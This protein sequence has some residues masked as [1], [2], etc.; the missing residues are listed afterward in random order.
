MCYGNFYSDGYGAGYERGWKEAMESAEQCFL[1]TARYKVR[2]ILEEKLGA[3]ADNHRA[4]F[5]LEYV[6]PWCGKE[7]DVE[8]REDEQYLV[9]C[10][11]RVVFVNANSP[12]QAAEKCVFILK[13]LADVHEDDGTMLG[14]T[15][16]KIEDGALTVGNPGLGI[17]IDLEDRKC[18]VRLPHITNTPKPDRKETDQ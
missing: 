9:K 4:L 16:P 17:D 8:Y 11:C 2:E 3:M 10:P 7:V 15:R 18:W 12:Q 13:P 5:D 6:C 14:Y 1:S